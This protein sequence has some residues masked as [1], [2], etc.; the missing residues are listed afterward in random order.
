MELAAAIATGSILDTGTILAGMGNP[1]V[2]SIT[3]YPGFENEKSPARC[4]AVGTCDLPVIRQATGSPTNTILPASPT[5][6]TVNETAPGA[7]SNLA[8]NF[9][10]I[11]TGEYAIL[12]P[13]KI[14]R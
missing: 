5:A 7:I 13:F 2:K 12:E 10:A 6:A 8:L 9:A 14:G 3:E 4:A 11:K 1:F